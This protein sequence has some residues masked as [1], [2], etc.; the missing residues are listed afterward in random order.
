MVWWQSAADPNDAKSTVEWLTHRAVWHSGQLGKEW[1]DK[2]V[3]EL[4]SWQQQQRCVRVILC[5]RLLWK[6]G[7]GAPLV[8]STLIL[9][10]LYHYCCILLSRKK[11][12]K[13]DI[14]ITL[15]LCRIVSP[16]I[17]WQ[18]SCVWFCEKF[19]Q[20][21]W[22]ACHRNHLKAIAWS[23]KGSD[24]NRPFVTFLR[25][26]N[27]DYLCSV[28]LF[29]SRDHPFVQTSTMRRIAKDE[30][31]IRFHGKFVDFLQ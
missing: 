26:R 16:G 21:L 9:D 18:S 12:K 28:L 7:D 23:I 14:S 1:R 31:E 6:Q 19:R 15:F 13:I 20:R 25:N 22:K 8:G 4:L 10:W 17:R 3:R 24:R 29:E 2:G 5:W 11:R 27:M 30:H